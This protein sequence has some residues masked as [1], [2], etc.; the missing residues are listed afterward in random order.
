MLRS[1]ISATRVGGTI[2]YSSC[3]LSPEENEEVIDWAVNKTPDA[4]V[5]EKISL[6]NLELPPGLTK[7]K[8]KTFTKT[9]NTARILPSAQMEGFFVAKIKKIASTLPKK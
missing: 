9:Q 1:A 5:V 8:K 2:V 6:P 3:T 7:W 4:L